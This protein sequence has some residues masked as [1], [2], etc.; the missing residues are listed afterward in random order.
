MPALLSL[1]ASVLLSAPQAPERIQDPETT[2]QGRTTYLGR[3]VAQTM[4]WKGASWLMRRTREHEE[5]GVL[6]RQWLAV[7]PGQAVCDFGCGNGYHT[8]PLATAVGKE[9][10]VLAVDLQPQMLTMLRKRCEQQQLHN[11]TYIEATIDDPKLETASC[12]LILLVDVYHE[13]S[14]PV[15]VMAHLRSALKPGGRIVLVEFREEDKNVPIKPEHTMSKAQVVREMATH[16]MMLQAQFDG[17]PW[18]HAMAFTASANPGKRFAARQL[19]DAFLTEAPNQKLG[20]L[21]PFLRTG[22]S[23]KDLPTLPADVRGELRTGPGRRLIAELQRK[24]GTALPHDR[25]QVVLQEDAAGRWAVQAIRKR[26]AHSYGHGSSRP[27]VP[28]HNALGGGG[29]P[30]RIARAP[31]YGFDGVAWSL[32]KLATARASCE[33]NDCDLWSAYTVLDL[34]EGVEQRLATVHEAIATLAG[35]PGMLWLGL[36]NRAYKPRAPAGDETAIRILRALLARADAAG[37]EIALYPHYGFWMETAEV[38]KRLC[39]RIRHPR[40]GLCFN[41]CHFLRNHQETD[42]APLIRA[43]AP[44]LLAVTVSGAKGTGDAWSEL[45]QPLGNGDFDLNA[46]LQTLDD[47]KFR[48]PV[49]LQAYGIRQPPA[50]H[51]PVSMQAWQNA[52]TR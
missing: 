35:G 15:R 42:P 38:A 48:G 34:G 37:V 20:Q 5:N 23:P 3:E 8:L 26:Q 30:Q 14:H 36:Q 46:F 21:R 39:E 25:D 32:E 16:R 11:V 13:L 12:D 49:G 45:I 24:D 6:L 28:L 27:F 2:A 33:A 17:L 22:L 29:I 18:Q 43:C 47:V 51:L 52:V 50:K 40:L 10:K 44:H 31:Q 7:Q 41:L 1:A 4:H 9:G 19:L